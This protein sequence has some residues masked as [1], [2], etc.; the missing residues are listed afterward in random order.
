MTLNYDDL[1]SSF[2][3]KFDLRRYTLV[4]FSYLYIRRDLSVSPGGQSSALVKAFAT[5][6][7][8]DV[9]RCRLTLSNRRCKCLELST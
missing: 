2:A 1:L 6:V 7:L 9:R 8:S 4:A 5:M 3:F